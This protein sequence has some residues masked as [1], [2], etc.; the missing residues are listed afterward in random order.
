[1]ENVAWIRECIWGF[2][3]EDIMSKKWR[4]RI[5]ACILP[6]AILAG[7]GDGSGTGSEE[8]GN[9]IVDRIEPVDVTG[10]TDP[11]PEPEP[12]PE[13]D[14]AALVYQTGSLSED[15]QG[16]MLEAMT[17]LHQNLEVPEYIGEGIHMLSNEEWLE[18]IC[19]GVYEGSRSYSLQKGGDTL[20]V[21]QLGLDIEGKPYANVFYPGAEGSVLVL[22]Q[23]GSTTWLLQASVEKGKYEGAFETWLF[24]SESGHIQWEQ[25][26]YSAGVIVGEYKKSEYTGGSG[27]ASDMWT[28]RE[29]FDYKTTT[30]TYDENG[31]IAPTA[32]PTPTATPKP[33]TQTPKPTPQPTPQPTPEP[34][35]EPPAQNPQPPAQTPQP[36][37]EPT[38]EPPEDT[39]TPGGDT[40]IGWSP[41][42][43]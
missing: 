43:M 15:E 41:D 18:E 8:S 24:D 7:C 13:P 1:M 2:R 28:N 12:T 39:P 3:W 29:N 25:G 31:A 14:Q 35:P 6:L 40:D 33:P 19:Q 20:L 9:G 21:L 34:T 16:K 5:A 32:T 4:Y 17:T 23:T 38:P 11:T 22:K 30:V 42:L 10:L 37:P 27:A 36:T 26:T